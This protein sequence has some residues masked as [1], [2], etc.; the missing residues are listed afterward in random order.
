MFYQ[1]E[2][3]YKLKEMHWELKSSLVNAHLTD[4]GFGFDFPESHVEIRK[5]RQYDCYY[6][7]TF[8]TVMK[9][10]ESSF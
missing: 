5:G 2:F 4:F 3:L 7:Q 1:V 6:W 10:L 9:W 8:W